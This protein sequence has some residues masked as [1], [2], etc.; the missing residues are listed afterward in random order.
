[1]KQSCF[2]SLGDGKPRFSRH[3]VARSLV[4]LLVVVAPIVA[5]LIPRPTRGRIVILPRLD[6]DRLEI[7]AE[8]EKRRGEQALSGS[9]PVGVRTVGELFRRL[10]HA[11]AREPERSRALLSELREVTRE[12]LAAGRIRELLRLRALQSELFVNQV[13]RFEKS[14]TGDRQLEELA[15]DF[16]HFLRRFW[17]KGGGI[18]LD[19]AELRL[20]F[21]VRWGKLTGTYRRPIFGPQLEE[22]RAYYAIHLRYPQAS[23]DEAIAR[24]LEQLRSTRALGRVDPNF[25]TKLATGVLLL[26][27]QRPIRAAAALRQYLQTRPHG[28]YALAARNHLLFAQRSQ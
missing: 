19:D 1:M 20:L 8:R 14:G 12:Q 15:G 28:P 21:R 27:A 22:L 25:P 4:L 16:E 9:L 6:H 5:L 3:S 2:R 26:R 11:L 23:P 17:E 24:S 10:G 7:L 18:R 13:K